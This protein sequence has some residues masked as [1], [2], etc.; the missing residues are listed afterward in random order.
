MCLDGLV[1]IE[2]GLYGIELGLHR[3]GLTYLSGSFHYHLS[4]KIIFRVNNI[5]IYIYIYIYEMKN[6]R[7]RDKRFVS[8]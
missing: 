1:L 7:S 8:C 5:Y 6:P 4:S 2:V 3:L